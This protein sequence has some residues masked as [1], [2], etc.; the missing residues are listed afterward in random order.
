MS[1]YSKMWVKLVNLLTTALLLSFN[2]DKEQKIPFKFDALKE[3]ICSI[4]SPFLFLISSISVCHTI[5]IM[6]LDDT[7]DLQLWTWL[8]QREIMVYNGKHASVLL[9][10]Y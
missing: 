5:H 4:F 10:T 9:G 3:Q 1:F 7:L 2:Y 6:H 8:V